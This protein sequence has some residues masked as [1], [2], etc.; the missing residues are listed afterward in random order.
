MHVRAPCQLLCVLPEL[1]WTGGIAGLD[2]AGYASK[3]QEGGWNKCVQTSPLH[4]RQ[5]QMLKLPILQ[6]PTFSFTSSSPSA[7]SPTPPLLAVIHHPLEMSPSLQEMN[8]LQTI[9]DAFLRKSDLSSIPRGPFFSP[10]LFC[11]AA[12]RTF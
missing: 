7:F 6:F 5:A 12:K 8:T 10:S 1:S 4:D 3:H 2:S 11:G 9:Y